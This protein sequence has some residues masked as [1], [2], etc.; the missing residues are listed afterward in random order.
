MRSHEQRVD[1]AF[2]TDRSLARSARALL[3]LTWTDVEGIEHEVGKFP[4]LICRTSPYP[5][6]QAQPSEGNPAVCWPA[7]LGFNTF[8]ML[9]KYASALSHFH[10]DVTSAG[11]RFAGQE[12]RQLCGAV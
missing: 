6:G 1:I 5:P 10:A 8:G 3:Q 9:F 11:F 2:H 4:P 12:V 7:V